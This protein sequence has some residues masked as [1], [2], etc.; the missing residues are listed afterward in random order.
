MNQSFEQVLKRLIGSFIALHLILAFGSIGFYYLS[1]EKAEWIDCLYMTFITISTIGYGEVIDMNN[2]AFGK[3]YTM[4]VA[5]S[6]IGV[7]TYLLS[8]M[9]AIIVEGNLNST[10]RRRKMDKKLKQLE[11]HYIVCGAGQLGHYVMEE[12]DNTHRKYVLIDQEI[13]ED[14]EQLTQKYSY[15]HFVEGDVTDNDVLIK[16]GIERASGIFATT[17]DDHENLVICL[18]AKQLNNNIR[19]IA[20]CKD[21]RIT[22]KMKRAGADCVIS[23]EHIGG[24]RM[25]SEMV[26]SNV[27][28]FLNDMLKNKEDGVR[29]EEVNLSEKFIGKKIDDLDI[30]QF[31]DALLVGLRVNDRQIF[32]PDKDIALEKNTTLIFM[33]KPDTRIK[34]E[35]A[36]S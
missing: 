16:A 32:N 21:V 29:F 3:F 36:F 14:L 12:L 11:N 20:H 18:T 22:D 17:D 2:S 27:V 26:R 30:N 28:S 33:S 23:S 9:T 6:G 10:F 25:T 7:I 34:L 8:N 31:S 4:A 35:E 13:E 5:L 15:L 1:D 19:I 24:M